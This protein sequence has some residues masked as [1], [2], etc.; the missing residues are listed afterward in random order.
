MDAQTRARYEAKS[1]II[2]SLAH[3]TR[4]FII[5]E[6]ARGGERCVCELTE[7][8][9]A[10]MSTVSKHLAL[11][12][13]AGILQDEKRG[14][15]VFYRLRVN[16]ILTFFD[17]VESVLMGRAEAQQKLFARDGIAAPEPEEE[18]C[19]VPIRMNVSWMAGD[20]PILTPQIAKA[21]VR[22]SG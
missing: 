10:D 18:C 3:P 15:M 13:D 1:K 21:P 6:L 7:M 2:K 9:G 17:C 14:S 19:P 22:A 12:K 11:L 8:V 4:L 16:C 5:D 20:A